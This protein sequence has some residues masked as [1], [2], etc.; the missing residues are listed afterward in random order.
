[1]WGRSDLFWT[2]RTS[3][4][5]LYSQP[6]NIKNPHRNIQNR[7]LNPKGNL[8]NNNQKHLPNPWLITI[9]L[10]LNPQEKTDS[11]D[12]EHSSQPGNS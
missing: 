3:K 12:L 4:L 8:F 1:V 11:E 9:S 6:P 10:H 5:K 2:G 7:L